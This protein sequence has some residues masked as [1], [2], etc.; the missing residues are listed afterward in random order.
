MNEIGMIVIGGVIRCTLLALV[1]LVLGM[2]LRRR[3]P[4]AGSLVSLT[5]LLLLLAL[6]AVGLSPWPR[7]WTYD[8]TMAARPAE[9]TPSPSTS[10]VTAR[11]DV[12]DSSA[13]QPADQSRNPA[14]QESWFLTFAREFERELRQPS[15]AHD[16]ARWRWPA[17]VAL[18]LLASLGVGLI[19]LVVGLRAVAVLRRSCRPIEDEAMLDALAVCRAEMCCTIPVAILESAEVS[20]PATIGWRRP[21]ILLPATWTDWN[22]QER[23]V[24]LAH[25]LAHISRGDYASGVLAQLSVAVHFYHPLAHW[26]A[27]RLRLQQELAADA[28]GARLSGGHRPY[29][30]ILARMALRQSERPVSWPAR[31]FLPA[32]GMF[33]RRLEMLRD[34]KK[35]RHAPLSR[36]ARTLTVAALLAAGLLVAGFRGPDGP[37]LAFAQGAEKPKGGERDRCSRPA[38]EGRMAPP[39]CIRAGG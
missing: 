19:R 8:A 5:T 37:P 2:L 25:E 38:S 18:G 27:A 21:I 32:R 13:V 39:P 23:R 1:G 31:S 34:P 11:P 22:E 15:V 33:L 28:W 36:A 35:I 6:P 12:S 29:V 26:L 9:P 30:T 3:G 4:A 17:W 16:T 10:P 20:T 7:W 14:N 24:V